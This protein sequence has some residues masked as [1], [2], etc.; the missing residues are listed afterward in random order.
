MLLMEPNRAGRYA[1]AI[2]QDISTTSAPIA[3]SSF[4]SQVARLVA[5]VLPGAPDGCGS[6]VVRGSL[7]RHHKSGRE[8]DDRQRTRP[9]RSTHPIRG[10]GQV[11][12]HSPRQRTTSPHPPRGSRIAG[13]AA[14]LA[15]PASRGVPPS[16]GFHA[17]GAS[18]GAGRQHQPSGSRPS[19]RGQFLCGAQRRLTPTRATWRSA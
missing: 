16:V 12:A 17:C 6:R 3:L 10:R 14:M 11:N 9:V 1:L 8:L 15:T 18:C 7:E 4:R 13:V 2:A 19:A 5:Y